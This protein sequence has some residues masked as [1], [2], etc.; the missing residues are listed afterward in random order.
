MK[1]IYDNRN[2][3]DKINSFFDTIISDDAQNQLLPLPEQTLS[4]VHFP[5]AQPLDAFTGN[6]GLVYSSEEEKVDSNNEIQSKRTVEVT[7]LPSDGGKLPRWNKMQE[8][9]RMRNNSTMQTR[10][11]RVSFSENTI[12]SQKNQMSTNA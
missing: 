4:P 10:G 6:D 9:R 3:N 5:E 12:A 8:E 7:N 2:A 11:L 1:L